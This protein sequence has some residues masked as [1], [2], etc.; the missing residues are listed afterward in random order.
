MHAEETALYGYS[1]IRQKGEQL[2]EEGRKRKGRERDRQKDVQVAA[3]ALANIS[4]M[5]T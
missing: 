1:L 3:H 5:K 2:G 4:R